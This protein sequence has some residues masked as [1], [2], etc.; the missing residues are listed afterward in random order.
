MHG[1]YRDPA[2][3]LPKRGTTCSR[4]VAW[5]Q[6]LQLRL[7]AALEQKAKALQ[8]QQV[9]IALPPCHPRPRLWKPSLLTLAVSPF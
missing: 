6:D 8:R 3:Y 5:R 2:L 1:S 7:D 9:P 4:T